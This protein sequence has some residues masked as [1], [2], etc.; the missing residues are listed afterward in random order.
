MHTSLEEA[1]G[2]L[3]ASELMNRQAKEDM[4]RLLAEIG[5][6]Q[7]NREAR[8]SELFNMQWQSLS[9]LRDMKMK[10]QSLEH[11]ATNISQFCTNVKQAGEAAS[12][13]RLDCLRIKCAVRRYGAH[14]ADTAPIS[15]LPLSRSTSAAA[16]SRSYHRITPMVTAGG[17]SEEL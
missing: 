3:Q 10:L 4:A 14:S 1:N 8:V 9:R 7:M 6:R 11:D 16:L 5:A 13:E 12:G 17:Q 2:R 15:G